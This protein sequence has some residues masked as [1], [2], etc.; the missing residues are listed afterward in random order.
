MTT[1]H[2]L[3]E[4]ALTPGVVPPLWRLITKFFYFGGLAVAMGAAVVYVAAVRPALRMASTDPA[5]REVLRRQ[6]SFVLAGAG[7][8]LLA[9]LYPQLAG[10]V[11]RAGEGMEFGAALAPTA[12]GNYLALPALPGDWVASGVFTSIQF[13]GPATCAVL[14]ILLFIPRLRGCMDVFAWIAAIGIAAA[15]LV[16]VLPKNFATP[17]TSDWAST[18]LTDIHPISGCIWV[19]GLVALGAL[20]GARR[21][22]SAGSGLIWAKV[23]K[24]FSVVAEVCVGAV[25]ASG[26][27]LA[28]QLVGSISQLW[29]TPFGQMLS[30]KILLVFGLLAMGAYN[31]FVLL[32]RVTRLRVAGDE[33]SLFKL[34]LHHF[35]RSV[36]VEVVLGIAVLVVIPFLNDS[37]REQA[38]ES[39]DPGDTGGIFAAIA[40]LI[41]FGIIAF[42]ASARM[43]LTVEQRGSRAEPSPLIRA[44]GTE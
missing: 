11:A 38:G 7:A 36:A 14:L 22:L 1:T 37:A 24:R 30:I 41:V 6:S 10:K 34:V 18:I 2:S 17:T 4:A 16:T 5:D 32:P 42:V 39:A 35:P 26:L 13:A 29:T 12:I 19:G 23:W 44:L 20:A 40:V 33:H 25:L 21:Q 9:S 43:H 8:I 27:F 31:E 15:T 28:W 3:I